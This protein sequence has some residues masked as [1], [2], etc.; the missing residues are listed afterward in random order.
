M[1]SIYLRV[2]GRTD[3]G[4]VRKNN[5]DSF[6]V[7]DLTGTALIGPEGSS[8]RF[9]V[10]ERGVLLAVS[11]GMGGLKAGEVASALVTET[12]PKAMRG[13]RASAPTEERLR[14]GVQQAHEKVWTTAQEEGIRMGATLTAVYVQGEVAWIAEVGDSR[15]YLIR[16]GKISQLTKDQSLVQKLLDSGAVSAEDA[17]H[18]PYR[19]VILQAMGH[20]ED[21]AVAL[22]RLELRARDC[23]VLCSDGLTTH[24]S[25]EDIRNVVL[26]AP[27]LSVACDRL[28]NLAKARGGLDNITAVLAG[29]GGPLPAPRVSSEG[30]EET[31]EV[32]QS[33][34]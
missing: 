33:F 29:L 11:D 18:S 5:E 13:G 7:A 12:L 32:V 22:G 24:L 26:S 6:V 21:V 27:D 25:D 4:N 8:G 16:A 30:V 10:G 15:A 14:V 3:I 28:V 17:A 23:L 9:E 31:F 20:Q 34:G 1:S 2:V 19:S